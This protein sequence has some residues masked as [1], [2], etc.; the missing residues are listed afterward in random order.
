M[1]FSIG[2]R[3]I[4]IG[5]SFYPNMNFSKRKIAKNGTKGTIVR[6]ISLYRNTSKQ[7]DLYVVYFDGYDCEDDLIDQYSSESLYYIN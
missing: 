5:G 4:K 3:V 1:K 6:I 7:I 2:D